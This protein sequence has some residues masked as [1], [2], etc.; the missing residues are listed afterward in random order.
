MI[1]F[2]YKRYTIDCNAIYNLG[3]SILKKTL[4][5]IILTLLFTSTIYQSISYA[6][7]YTKWGLPD[8][9]IARFGKGSIHEITYSP[10]N[11]LLA[12]ASSIGI[13]LYD[14]DTLQE[15]ALLTGHTDRVYSVAF[16]PD[17]K[18]IASG[19]QDNT[20][21]LWNAETG[22]HNQTLNGHTNQVSS[23]AFS[24]DGKTIASGSWDR[25]IRIWNA[26]T[27][28][29]KKHYKDIRLRSLA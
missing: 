23:V 12:V 26:E 13:W 22:E 2:F 16:S 3:D 27:A 20:I 14:A 8:G 24:P 10:D 5:T 21:R 19:S 4:F 15:H 6:Q 1:L 29:H 28:E 18:T 11:S 7:D 25:T 9:A 17:G